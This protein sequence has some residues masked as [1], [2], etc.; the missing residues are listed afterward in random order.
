MTEPCIFVCMPWQPGTP[1]IVEDNGV[2]EC[3]D[4]QQ[5]IQFRPSNLW[6]A[7]VHAAPSP[8]TALCVDCALALAQ[9]AT[10]PQ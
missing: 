5:P 7:T 1:L 8:V 9:S 10:N 6:A 4:C 3:M 2:M